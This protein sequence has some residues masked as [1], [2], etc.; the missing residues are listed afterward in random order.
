MD[1]S[2]LGDLGAFGLLCIVI[3]YVIRYLREENKTKD[4]TIEKLR[5]EIAD[6]AIKNLEAS[7]RRAKEVQTENAVLRQG[8]ESLLGR[9]AQ[10]ERES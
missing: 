2:Q 8:M 6:Q 9:L 4:A 1:P 7:E 5:A 10:R 3:F